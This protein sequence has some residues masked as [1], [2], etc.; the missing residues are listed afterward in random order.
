MNVYKE[1]EITHIFSLYQSPG[2]DDLK[3]SFE[4]VS[5]CLSPVFHVLPSELFLLLTKVSDCRKQEHFYLIEM[6]LYLNLV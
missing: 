4:N 6:S 2:G 3:E 5:S 1:H